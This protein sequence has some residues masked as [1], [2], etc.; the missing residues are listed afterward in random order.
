MK[1]VWNI[2]SRGKGQTLDLEPYLYSYDPDY[3]ED[4]VSTFDG[5]KSIW[6]V[7][8][9]SQIAI[10][11]QMNRMWLPLCSANLVHFYTNG[12]FWWNWMRLNG[13]EISLKSCPVQKNRTGMAQKSISLM[14][15]VFMY[16]KWKI[17]DRTGRLFFKTKML[18]F[19]L[20]FFTV[21]KK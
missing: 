6:S 2:D 18:Y 13:N 20:T 19:I 12:N 14:P 4:K 10:R 9:M 21:F 15:G 5:D 7:P 16:S 3:P 8:G 17:N 1:K 11:E